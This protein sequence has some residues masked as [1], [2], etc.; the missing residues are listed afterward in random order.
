MRT[1]RKTTVALA[2]SL[3]LVSNV[4]LG[5]AGETEENNTTTKGFCTT[6][7]CRTNRSLIL[8]GVGVALGKV[9]DTKELDEEIKLFE[10][11]NQQ[12]KDIVAKLLDKDS[13]IKDKIKVFEEKKTNALNLAKS[14]NGNKKWA[15]ELNAKFFQQKIKNL[16]NEQSKLQ[17]QY[18][19]WNKALDEMNKSTANLKEALDT[20]RKDTKDF[21]K[22]YASN[23]SKINAINEIKMNN[24]KIGT[25]LNG[26][27][28]AIDGALAVNDLRKDAQE[29]SNAY[30]ELSSLFDVSS[31]DYWKEFA[32]G[33]VNLP[34]IAGISAGIGSMAVASASSSTILKIFYKYGGKTLGKF[35]S[36]FVSWLGLLVPERTSEDL[37]APMPD[38]NSA[39]KDFLSWFA[40]IAEFSENYKSYIDEASKQGKRLNIPAGILQ[41]WQILDTIE[42]NP[43]MAWIH[44]W[45][46]DEKGYAVWIGEQNETKLQLDLN[47]SMLNKTAAIATYAASHVGAAPAYYSRDVANYK[48]TLKES[49]FYTKGTVPIKAPVDIVLNWGERPSDLDSHLTGPMGDNGNFHVWY[50]SRGSLDNAPYVLLYRD[51]TSHGHGS[52]LPEQTRINTTPNGIYNF[53]V[54]DY[55]NAGNP[56]SRALSQSD[57]VVTIHSAGDRNKPEGQN[58]GKPVALFNVPKDKVGTVWHAFTINTANG[59]V[60]PRDQIHLDT[61]VITG[62][63][64]LSK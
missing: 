28:A 42:P 62:G 14:S 3:A 58:L 40:T 2:V 48:R 31:E 27:F 45:S 47:L 13:E 38:P 60:S 36:K 59:T 57:A 63:R 64:P 46:I 23:T 5:W 33:F 54:H 22:K 29:L 7:A 19:A 44:Y 51:D 25:A 15:Y 50:G 53:Y 12:I 61:S 4:A 10:Q 26:V 20:L 16:K 8:S 11:K 34:T 18:K 17:K 30:P 32:G 21:A 41:F 56:N 43:D 1:M 6:D 52:T 37:H 49:E 35:G 39:K 24:L 55:S 9:F